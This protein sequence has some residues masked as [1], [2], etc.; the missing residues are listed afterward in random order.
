MQMAEIFTH[1]V[2]MRDRSIRPEVLK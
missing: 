2:Y 1:R